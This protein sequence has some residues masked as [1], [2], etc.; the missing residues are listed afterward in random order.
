[1]AFIRRDNPGAAERLRQRIDR[2][3]RGLEQFPESGR[4]V[5][6]F[7]R[8]PYKEVVVAPYRLFYTTGEFGILIVG[9]WHGAQLPTAPEE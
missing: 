9:V 1:M 6:E 4:V 8:L 2:A 3:L 7:P 5:P